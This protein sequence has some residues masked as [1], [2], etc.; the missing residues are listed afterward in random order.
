MKSTNGNDNRGFSL[1]EVAIAIVVIGLIVSFAL[2]GKE[3]IHT[4]KLNAVFDQVESF[5][6]ATQMFVEKYGDIPG[7]LSNAK[8][9]IDDSLENGNGSGAIS[10]T[11]D[12]K[13]FW[14]HLR[15]SG[16]LTLEL[17]NGYPSSKI[18][19]FFFVSSSVP[20]C[21]GVW[22]ILTMTTN[23]LSGLKGAI[24]QEDAY[25]ID[26]K[27]DTGNPS[28][29][30]IRAFKATSSGMTPI[31]QKYDIKNK[32]KDCILMFKIW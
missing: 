1:I 16:L 19:G 24:S 18:G 9:M 2:K 8:E 27:S 5:K 21:D 6:I 23:G 3:L 10:S 29:G 20:N 17:I 26:R 13:R 30:E 32:N 28:Y 15:A 14:S 4:A 22:I 31:E 25:R 7:S 11:D 12:A